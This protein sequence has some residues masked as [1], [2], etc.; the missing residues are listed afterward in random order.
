MLQEVGRLF[1]EYAPNNTMFRTTEFGS[2]EIVE[3]EKRLAAAS[4]DE[5]AREDITKY[6]N[7]MSLND[8]SA[9]IPRLG[10]EEIIA[11]GNPHFKPD[12]VIVGSPKYL[13]S[14]SDVLDDTDDM[15]V[16]SYFVWKIIQSYASA[17]DSPIVQ[18][19]KRFNNVL[20]GREPDA[21]PERWRTCIRSV[22]GGLGICPVTACQWFRH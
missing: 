21:K 11:K 4:P 16:G 22:D 14:L 5:E 9:L 8:T 3:F 12:R 1:E 19:L 15:V 2:K 7:Q 10:L 20:G 17:V 18:P 6:Y 13:K